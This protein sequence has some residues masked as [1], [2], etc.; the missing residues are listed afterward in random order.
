LC[1]WLKSRN[2]L[3]ELQPSGRGDF[4]LY[5]NEDDDFR[6][7]PTLTAAQLM[8]VIRH[9]MWGSVQTAIVGFREYIFSEAAGALGR[10]AAATEYAFGTISQVGGMTK[11]RA[12]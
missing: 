10:F 4:F 7:P 11:D 5:A 9:R 12:T 8:S 1:E 2:L 3:A 6:I